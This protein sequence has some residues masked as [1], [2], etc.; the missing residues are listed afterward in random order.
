MIQYTTGNIFESGASAIVNTVNLV[1]V[2]GKG[3]ALQFK[4]R[5]PLN[6]KLYKKACQTGVISIG[7]MFVTQC[8]FEDGPGYIVNF[9]TKN[10]WHKPSEYSYIESGLADLIRV[11]EEYRL[12]SIAIPPL[13]AGNGGLDWSE[14]KA[15]IERYL[16]NIDCDIIVYEPSEVACIL[17]TSDAADE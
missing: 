8:G 16:G 7:Q 13:G 2:M 10:D 11:I 4:K 12:G 15:L 14:V 6:F 9:P 3:L 5:Y 17:Y 1:G